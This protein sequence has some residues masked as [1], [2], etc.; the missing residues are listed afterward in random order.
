M[1]Q[2]STLKWNYLA[3]QLRGLKKFF[4]RKRPK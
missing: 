1:S 3:K 2:L 4:K